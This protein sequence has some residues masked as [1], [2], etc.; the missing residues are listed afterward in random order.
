VDAVAAF[1]PTPTQRAA[2]RFF[3]L[4]AVVFV[5]QVLAGVLTVHDFV[6][7][8]SFFGVD[9]QAALPVTVAR[10]WH[11]QLSLLWIALC[12]IGGS[13]FVLPMFAG[14]EPRGQLA[15]VNGLFVLAL[16]VGAGTCVGIYLG[17]MGLLG[18]HW[19]LLGNQ[20]WEI[21]EM[22]RLWQGLLFVALIAWAVVVIR[23]VRPVMTRKDPIAL[24][25]WLAYAVGA[26]V[27][28]FTSGFVAGP[29]ENFVIADFWRWMV[30]HMWAEAFLEVLTTV[31]V[32]CFM[33]LMGLVTAKAASR[34]VT[35]A[36]LL[37]LGSGI[38]GISHNFYW[39]AKPVVTL[40]LGAVF[41]TL[42]VVP[43]MLL[44][45]DA[46]RTRMLPSDA[47]REARRPAGDF[48]QS[49]AFLFLLGVSFWNFFGAGVLGLVINLP[50][51]N[52]YEH[53]T[54]LTV[55][56]GHA[57]LMGVYG[58]LSLA[59]LVFVG[60][61]LVRPERFPDRLMR[62]AFWSL[63]VG[64]ALTV[65]LD[66]LPAGVLQLDAV[67]EKGFWFARSQAFIDSPAFQTLT[68]MR[69]VG[70]PIFVVGGL[71]PIAWFALSRARSLKP[72]VALTAPSDLPGGAARGAT[73]DR[74]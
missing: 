22:G 61:Y 60:R 32:S 34:V 54:T 18:P 41:S 25:S 62:I 33:V 10:G 58:N 36:A 72:L 2:W 23:G 48:G 15:L 7:L 3:L 64:L 17:P 16:V 31:V 49:A 12:W 74:R 57:A 38:L 46:W 66:L 51:V 45:A 35:L 73:L 24:P 9:L 4:A 21:V 11:V 37:F 6:K 63:N 20:G 26:V 30:V 19:R 53:G 28:L 47:L 69:A 44:A 50:I 1:R 55:N 40:A 29:R 14:K 13:I 27:V 8:T 39:N 67:L 70:G 59:A 43:L 5:V 71:V 65:L 56:H 52:Y 42:Q 68:W